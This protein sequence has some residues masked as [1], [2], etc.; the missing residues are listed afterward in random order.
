MRRATGNVRLRQP[1]CPPE[2]Y[3]SSRCSRPP[4]LLGAASVAEAAD[5]MARVPGLADCPNEQRERWAQWLEQLCPRGPDGRLGGLQPDMLAETHV[6]SQL[7]ADS[8]LAQSC[9]RGLSAEQAERALTVL[10]RACEHQDR[11]RRLIATALRDDLAGLAL[12]AARVALQDA[13]DLGDLL[14]DAL[15]D[16]PASAEVLTD[17]ALRMPYPSM[18]LALAHLTAT[19]RV[20]ESLPDDTD[21]E[22]RAVWDEREARLRSELSDVAVRREP[23]R[24]AASPSTADRRGQHRTRRP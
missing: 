6:V 2:P 8:R 17:I 20:R 9:L 1:G 13:R 21:P 4:R 12:P 19:A 15:D 14:A 22:T 16:A 18:A 11:A 5:V 7:A 24:E 3:W 10:A 23:D